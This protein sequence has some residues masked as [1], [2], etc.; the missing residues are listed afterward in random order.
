MNTDDLLYIIGKQTVNIEMMARRIADLEALVKELEKKAREEG[1][2][3]Q[4]S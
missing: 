4:R 2:D 1:A 3:G